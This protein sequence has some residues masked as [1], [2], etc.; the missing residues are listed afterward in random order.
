MPKD[1]HGSPGYA[2]RNGGD[3]S[4]EAR[5]KQVTRKVGEGEGHNDSLGR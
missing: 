1:A 5:A 3:A 2:K 4:K